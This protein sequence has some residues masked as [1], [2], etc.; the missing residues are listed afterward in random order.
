MTTAVEARP[1]DEAKLG[2]LINKAVGDF[3]AIMSGTLVA[4]GDKLGLFKAISDGGSVTSADLAKRSGC[5]ERYVREWLAAMAAS[6]N[7]T[8]DGGGRYSLSPEQEVFFTD[9]N[10]PAGLVGGYQIT[11]AATR[12][13]GRIVQAFQTGQGVGWHEQDPEL[14]EGTERFFRPGYIGNLIGSWLP[15]LDGVIE[16]LERG[17][18]VADVGCGHGASTILMAE[19]F[20]NSQFVG[21]DYHQGSI[22]AARHRAADAGLTNV[23]FQVAS[24]KEYPGTYDL[25][26][27]FDCL[28]DMG[29]PAGAA[30]HTYKSLND[31][32]TWMV[33]EPNA[34]DDV[35]DNLNPVGRV[36]YSASTLLCT[37]GSLSQEVGTALGAQ[38]GQARLTEVA[39][40]GGFKTLRR[41]TETP[42]NI[43]LEGRK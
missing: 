16:R 28:H 5:A 19:A 27:Y 38:A 7:I 6:G 41:A 20:P 33:I 21:F 25:V 1:V 39:Q 43:V 11:T 15:A 36:F 4:V 22:D 32:G 26:C 23:T 35:A 10:S 8:Y 9:P 14:F 37:P 24:A 17:I 12:S 29:D 40:K 18:K 3:G 2:D 30:A 34:Q 31:G 13:F 42:F